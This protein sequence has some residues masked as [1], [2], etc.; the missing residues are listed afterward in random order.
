MHSETPTDALPALH[1]RL[2]AWFADLRLEL[3]RAHEG[4]TDP[5]VVHQIRVLIRRLRSAFK[6]ATQDGANKVKGLKPFD[7]ALKAIANASGPVRDADVLEEYLA[8]LKDQPEASAPGW[9]EAIGLLHAELV[10]ARNAGRRDLEEVSGQDDVAARLAR[11]PDVLARLAAAAPAAHELAPLIAARL[12]ELGEHVQAARLAN[13]PEEWHE[14]RI[15]IKRVRYATELM[16]G[17]DS[18][19]LEG[20]ARMQSV[21]GKAHDHRVWQARAR[22]LRK[23]LSRRGQDV[24]ARTGL[25]AIAEREGATASEHEQKF[26]LECDAAIGDELREQLL[27]AVGAAPASGPGTPQETTA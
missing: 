22:E 5:E 7:R 11:G 25:A 1:A 8:E 2:E 19:L 4:E 16:A 24:L 10:D 18:P 27:A 3:S 26:S 17:K 9:P 23:S 6:V 20:F 12:A 14:V 13:D 15:A 21:L